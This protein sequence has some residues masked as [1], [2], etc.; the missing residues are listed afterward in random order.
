MVSAEVCSVS[1]DFACHS[2]FCLRGWSPRLILWR[3]FFRTQTFQAPSAID[4]SPKRNLKFSPSHPFA[5][6]HRHVYTSFDRPYTNRDTAESLLVLQLASLDA[7]AKDIS[8]RHG[9]APPELSQPQPGDSDDEGD[10]EADDA[11]SGEEGDGGDVAPDLAG[12]PEEAAEAIG[13]DGVSEFEEL[14]FFPEQQVEVEG[15]GEFGRLSMSSR[16]ARADADPA[17][18][19]QRGQR[20]RRVPRFRR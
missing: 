12:D 5:Q 19:P 1:T 4:S 16:A 10:G 13:D 15:K 6:N 9:L 7:E 20:Q 18:F 17:W 11:G 8:A 3:R 14:P 2:L